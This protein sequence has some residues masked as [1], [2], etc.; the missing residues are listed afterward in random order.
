MKVPE[1][2]CVI[3]SQAMLEHVAPQGAAPNL[4]QLSA[5]LSAAAK[6]LRVS[7]TEDVEALNNILGQVTLTFAPDYTLVC[8]YMVAHADTLALL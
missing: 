2:S 4:E 3:R 6:D 7:T 8:Y 1:R 5:A